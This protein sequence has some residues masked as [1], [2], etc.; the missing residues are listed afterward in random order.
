VLAPLDEL[1]IRAPQAIAMYALS[2]DDPTKVPVIPTK[3]GAMVLISDA[4]A[5]DHCK[6]DLEKAAAKHP[7]WCIVEIDRGPKDKIQVGAGS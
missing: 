4:Y 2:F 5:C 6:K 1:K 7:S 3:Y